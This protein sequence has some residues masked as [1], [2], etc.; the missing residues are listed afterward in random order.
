MQKPFNGGRDR[1]EIIFVFFSVKTS[2]IMDMIYDC[3]N[4]MVWFGNCQS[5]VGDSLLYGAR[6]T[7]LINRPFLGAGSF[8][9]HNLVWILTK[10]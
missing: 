7:E 1:I 8:W 5:V 10:R 2:L 6:F 4:L 9:G 3:M